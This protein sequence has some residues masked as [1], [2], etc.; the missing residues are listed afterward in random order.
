MI[1]LVLAV[2]AG[3]IPCLGLFFWLRNA[4]KKEETYRK[5]CTNA[6]IKGMLC[7]LW[8]FLASGVP[9]ILLRLTKL[10]DTNHLLYL[11]IYEMIVIALAEELVKYFTARRLLNK[12]D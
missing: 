4:L 1:P 9:S 11:A 10:Q 5:L 3:F 6:L 7:T 2:I 8:I 12:T